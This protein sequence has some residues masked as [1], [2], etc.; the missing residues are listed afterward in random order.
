[1]KNVLILSLYIFFIHFFVCIG[2]V[3][4]ILTRRITHSREIFDRKLCQNW[5]FRGV[6]F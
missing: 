3:D 1:M 4:K 6:N 2:T 5:Y